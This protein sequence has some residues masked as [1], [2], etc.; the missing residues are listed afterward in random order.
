M[1]SAQ[2]VLSAWI[3]C[4]SVGGKIRLSAQVKGHPTGVDQEGCK[5][6]NYAGISHIS[7][8]MVPLIRSQMF[9]N[10]S[11]PSGGQKVFRVGVQEVIPVI[12]PR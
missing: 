6:L 4:R 8:E 2:S 12:C 3:S 1:R 5:L 7:M 10:P 9:E 11:S